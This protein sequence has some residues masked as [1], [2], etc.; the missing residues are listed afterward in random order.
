MQ[1]HLV[2]SKGFRLHYSLRGPAGEARRVLIVGHTDRDRQCGGPNDFVHITLTEAREIHKFLGDFLSEIKSADD[3][4]YPEALRT[5]GDDAVYGPWE[6][7][8]G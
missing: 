4:S 2:T 8:V 5:R 1:H 7:T 3:K 6:K